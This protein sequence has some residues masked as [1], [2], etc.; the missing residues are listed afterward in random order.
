MPAI[1]ELPPCL[2]RCCLSG[3][4]ADDVMGR[5]RRYSFQISNHDIQTNPH[6]DP[7]NTCYSYQTMAPPSPLPDDSEPVISDQEAH[8]MLGP[9]VTLGLLRPSQIDAALQRPLKERQEALHGLLLQ[10]MRKRQ[11]LRKVRAFVSWCWCAVLVLV[12]RSISI[13]WGGMP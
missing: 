10:G 4:V 2:L 9:L 5:L 3:P 1:D 12:G 7:T 11:D 6:S 13:D 8:Q